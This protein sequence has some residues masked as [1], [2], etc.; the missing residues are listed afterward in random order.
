LDL[1]KAFDSV[2]H[3]IRVEKTRKIWYAWSTFR[4]I[5]CYLSNRKQYTKLNNVKSNWKNITCGVPHGSTLAPL[6]FLIYINDL[7]A[8]S[9]LHTWLVADDATLQFLHQQHFPFKTLL[10]QN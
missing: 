5:K 2:N 7:P 6:L 3:D 1:A 8:A 4:T 9:N 10:T